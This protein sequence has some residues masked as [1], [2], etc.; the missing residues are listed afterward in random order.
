MSKKQECTQTAVDVL[1]MALLSL[2]GSTEAFKAMGRASDIP[3]STEEDKEALKR[4]IRLL[5]FLGDL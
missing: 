5:T 3:E 2:E 4:C 1:G